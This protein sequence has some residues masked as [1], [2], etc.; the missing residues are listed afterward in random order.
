MCVLCAIEHA[1]KATCRLELGPLVPSI[2]IWARPIL[3]L[4]ARLVHGLAKQRSMRLRRGKRECGPRNAALGPKRDGWARPN[5]AQQRE[6]R[7]YTI[8]RHPWLALAEAD[9]VGL[10]LTSFQP[11]R[12]HLPSPPKA[13]MRQFAMRRRAVSAARPLLHH[14]EHIVQI[15][16]ACW[17][18]L[19]TMRGHFIHV[20]T[21]QLRFA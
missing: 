4:I 16:R 3:F 21:D 5:F 14:F 2:T 13:R 15:D 20:T 10:V 7:D 17:R 18:R 1:Q 19:Q 11:P 6:T 9:Q 12:P 8:S